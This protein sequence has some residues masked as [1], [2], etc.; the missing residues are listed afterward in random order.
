MRIQSIVFKRILSI[1][2]STFEFRLLLMLR[3]GDWKLKNKQKKQFI[4]YRFENSVIGNG[5]ADSDPYHNLT[6]PWHWIPKSKEPRV[7]YCVC[8]CPCLGLTLNRSRSASRVSPNH[9]LSKGRILN[10]SKSPARSKTPTRRVG[11]QITNCY[12]KIL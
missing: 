9:S 6:D 5:S 8:D 4:L 2:M 3:K 11:H 12:A 1:P 10:K 7:V